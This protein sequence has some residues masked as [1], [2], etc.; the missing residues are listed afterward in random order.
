MRDPFTLFETSAFAAALD[1][2]VATDSDAR[3]ATK[4]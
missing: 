4:A 1:A 2:L 3:A